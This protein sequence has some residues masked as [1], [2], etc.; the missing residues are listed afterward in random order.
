M[1]VGFCA[2]SR[3]LGPAIAADTG[4]TFTKDVAPILFGHCVECHRPGEAAPFSLLTYDDA[5]RKAKLIAE[6]T[7]KGAMPP[8][9]PD[10]H[11]AGWIGERRLSTNQITVLRRWFESGAPEGSSADLPKTPEFADGWQL[12]RPDLIVEMPRA[13]TLA[14]EGKDV[15]RN[16]VVPVSLP[17]R[18]YI[19]AVEFRPDNRRIVHHAFIKIDAT[20]AARR[21]ETKEKD[22]GFPGLMASESAMMPTGQFLSWQPGHG[23]C[24]SPDGF[25]WIL[26]PGT[27]LVLQVHMNPTGKPEALKA[28][29]GLYFADKPPAQTLF[30]MQLV[31]LNIDIPAGAS[32]HVVE[33]RFMLPVDVQIFAVLPHAHYLAR[34][35]EGTARLPDGSTQ[36][37]IRIR[38]WDFNWQTD[39]KFRTPLQLPRGTELTMRWTFDNSAANPRNPNNPPKPVRYGAQSSD[40]MA[41][42]WVQ[43][44]CR[45]KDLA[46]L[47]S[48]ADTHLGKQ[49]LAAEETAVRRNPADALARFNL[50]LV[51]LN[52]GNN[53]AA[54]AQFRE[55]LRLDP[56]QDRPHYNLAMVAKLEGR[57][58]EARRE[59]EAALAINPNNPRVHGNLGLLLADLQELDEAEKHFVSALR[60]DPGDTRAAEM[61]RRIREFKASSAPAKP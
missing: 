3:G 33:D 40:E 47:E 54:A 19:R 57:L 27:D 20:G 17:A 50:G 14:A 35:V 51:H 32:R 49:M 36:A 8:W 53:A 24:V 58:D 11:P 21:N 39:Y 29:V 61:I 4:P 37:L 56:K 28:S 16:F 46:A 13:Y 48:A 45:P 60:L 42:L 5:R 12:G 59:F 1:L 9:M 31:N 38:D 44:L 30:K 26:E 43:L 55:S 22:P 23:P 7:G 34:D 25:P 2:L 52:T 6:V 10:A 41:E 15:Y 18:R